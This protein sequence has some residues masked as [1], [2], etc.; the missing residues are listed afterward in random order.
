MP[1]DTSTLNGSLLEMKDQLIYEL[2]QKG[3]TASYDSTTGLLGL[4][5]KIGDIQTGG[6]SCYKVE[7]TSKSMTYGDWDFT[8]NSQVSLL[9]VYLQ[10]QYEPYSATVVISDG[11]NSYNVTTGADGYGTVTVPITASSTTF[12]AT[13]TGTSDTIT[14]TKSTYLFK[15]AC[16][17]A[18]G[19]SS[20][21]TY[22]QIYKSTSGNPSCV[23]S[24]DV[25]RNHHDD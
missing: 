11:T 10:S 1:N 25:D 24:Y 3:V 2:G 18:N 20:Y 8:Q 23:L 22:E 16:N 21:G 17:S 14:V 9:E 12:T 6:G 5:S 19:L 4:I 13:Y 7:F 15:D